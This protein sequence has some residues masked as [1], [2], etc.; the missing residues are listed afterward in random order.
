MIVRSVAGYVNKEGE[1]RGTYVHTDGH[2]NEALPKIQKR[3]K[4][5][6]Y[7][8][9]VKWV[10]QGI[11][12]AGFDSYD[13]DVAFSDREPQLMPY[14]AALFLQYAYKILPDGEINYLSAKP[15]HAGKKTFT[16]ARQKEYV[17]F[18]VK[19]GQT[20]ADLGSRKIQVRGFALTLAP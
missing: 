16:T 6:G 2:P 3:I 9:W 11:E 17:P 14:K 15:N 10:E 8:G 20:L 18:W 13:S 5:I 7:E 4:E 19:W 12:G 1:F